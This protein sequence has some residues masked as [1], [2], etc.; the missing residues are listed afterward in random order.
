MNFQVMPAKLQQVGPV[1][2]AAVTSLTPFK[3]SRDSSDR[4]AWHVP[5]A[6]PDRTLGERCV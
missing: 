4:T 2:A 6:A 5:T 3:A 1:I